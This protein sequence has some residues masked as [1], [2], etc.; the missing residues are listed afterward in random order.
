MES[1]QAQ[2]GHD[3][4]KRDLLENLLGLCFD[5][6]DTYG[7]DVSSLEGSVKLFEFTLAEYSNEVI[8]AAF[9]KHMRCSG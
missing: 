6:L 7:K 4:K 8:E 3:N 2:N 5:Q 9:M 1:L